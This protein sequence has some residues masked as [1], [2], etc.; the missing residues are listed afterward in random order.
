LILIHRGKMAAQG[1]LQPGE[2][3]AAAPPTL[4]NQEDIEV[5]PLERGDLRAP[6]AR[7]SWHYLANDIRLLNEGPRPALLY[8]IYF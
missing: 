7:E 8:M 1:P 5:V 2:K 4:K 6:D 3:D